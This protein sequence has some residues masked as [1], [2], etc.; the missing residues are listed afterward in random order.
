[1]RGAN[2]NDKFDVCETDKL[3]GENVADHRIRNG[4]TEIYVASCLD[5][6]IDDYMD[7]ESGA[8]PFSVIDIMKLAQVFGVEAE[9]LMPS[10]N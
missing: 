3:I 1:M 6:A 9:A 4:L 10:F 7:A 8:Y 5:M 2:D